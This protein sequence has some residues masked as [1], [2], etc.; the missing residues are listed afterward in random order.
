M[1]FGIVRAGFPHVD[2]QGDTIHESELRKAEASW[3]RSGARFKLGHAL[4][5][6]GVELASSEVLPAGTRWPEATSEPLAYPSKVAVV[7]VTDPA[8]R[9]MVDTG[10]IGAF[11]VGGKAKGGA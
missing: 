11:S 9:R 5:T 10:E 6:D 4:P 1:L 2:K 3:R 7:R 8:I